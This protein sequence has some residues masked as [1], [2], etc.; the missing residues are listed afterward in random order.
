VHVDVLRRGETWV[1]SC[2]EPDLPM[3][4]AVVR[5]WEIDTP[6][7]LRRAEAAIAERDGS[8]RA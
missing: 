6:G 1:Y 8:N 2:M 7:D 4:A 3:R 5:A